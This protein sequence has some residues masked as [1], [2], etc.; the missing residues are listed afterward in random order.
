MPKMRAYDGKSHWHSFK[1]QYNLLSKIEKWNT[2]EK[3]KNLFNF[4][5]DRALTHAIWHEKCSYKTL[6]K[7]NL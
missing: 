2:K 5:T 4:L 6:M 1:Y 7:N 3:K